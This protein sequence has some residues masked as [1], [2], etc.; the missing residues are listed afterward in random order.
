MGGTFGEGDVY[1]GRQLQVHLVEVLLQFL[2]LVLVVL[3]LFSRDEEV[4]EE[5][6]HGLEGVDLC[7]VEALEEGGVVRQGHVLGGDC[8]VLV[9][10]GV[11]GPVHLHDIA[12]V[13][14]HR[15]CLNLLADEELNAVQHLPLV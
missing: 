2:A 12:D 3:E 13:G 14:F 5:V 10:S 11:L 1:A 15:H 9:D 4:L 8:R 6:D 7:F